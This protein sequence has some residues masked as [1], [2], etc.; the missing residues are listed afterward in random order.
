MTIIDPSAE[1]RILRI[2]DIAGGEGVRRRLFALGFQPGDRVECGQRGIFGGPVVLK[3]LRTGVSMAV[4]RGIA[5]KILV[6][7]DDAD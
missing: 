1:G 5:R 4:G 6:A 3:N 2:V 7:V